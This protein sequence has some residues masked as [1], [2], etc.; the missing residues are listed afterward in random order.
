M[1]ENPLKDARCSA[2]TFWDP[3]N[4]RG[5]QEGHC[6]KNAP[7]PGSGNPRFPVTQYDDWCGDFKETSKFDLDDDDFPPTMANAEGAR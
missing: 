5:E 3:A 6:R 7:R 4:I 1:E 2:C